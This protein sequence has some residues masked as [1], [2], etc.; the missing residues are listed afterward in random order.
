MVIGRIY[1]IERSIHQLGVE[2]AEATE[3]APLQQGIL[4]ANPWHN[5][6]RRWSPVGRWLPVACL[7]RP[8]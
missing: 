4:A 2:V 8:A 1:G 6:L 3:P 5:V 7:G